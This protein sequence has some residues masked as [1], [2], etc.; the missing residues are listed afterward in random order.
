MLKLADSQNDI[1][2]GYLMIPIPDPEKAAKD[3][4]I[5]D[6]LESIILEG[7]EASDPQNWAQEDRLNKAIKPSKSWLQDNYVALEEADISLS[8]SNESYFSIQL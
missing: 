5:I 7:F 8:D 4:D 6:Q 3:K 1:R 2:L